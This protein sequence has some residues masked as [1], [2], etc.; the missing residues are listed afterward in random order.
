MFDS[1]NMYVVNFEKGKLFTFKDINSSGI[2]HFSKNMNY[3]YSRETKDK[4]SCL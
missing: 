2:L 1:F 4:A 3:C